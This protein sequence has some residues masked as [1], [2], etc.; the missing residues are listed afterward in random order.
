MTAPPDP[1]PENPFRINVSESQ[2]SQLQQ[3]LALTVLPSELDDAGW[4][5]GSPL[6]DIQRLVTRWKDGYSWKKYEAELN[7]ELPQFMRD[8]TVDGFGTLA[9]HYVHKRSQIPNAVPLLFVHGWPG[10]FIEVRKILPLL[11]ETSAEHPSFHV[12]ALSLPGF[13]F[14]DGPTKKGFNVARY[15]EVANKLMLSLGYQEYVTQGGDWGYYVTRAMAVEHG[16]KHLKAWHT[17]YPRSAS[18]IHPLRSP[19]KYLNHLVKPYTVSEQAALDRTAQFAKNGRGYIEIQCT[20]PQTLGFG[21]SDSPV[22]L[23]AWIYEKLQTWSDTNTYKWSDDEVL[24][25]VSIYWFSRAGPAA[26]L[27]IY[28]EATRSGDRD[29]TTATWEVKV[30]T[31]V[32]FFPK[33]FHLPPRRFL[34]FGN[35]VSVAEHTEEE[36]GGHFAAYEKPNLLVG[37]LRKMF[38]K[39]GGAFGAVTG[40]NGYN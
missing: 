13:G 17:N 19:L 15:A 27:R 10:S 2:I 23:L 36:G 18:A 24:T 25:W 5:Y 22:G 31:G 30:P 38:G 3:K 21:L 4:A 1:Y 26:S 9:I 6:P 20:Q 29:I 16:G 7:D 28:Y 34:A 32:S 37:D 8:I 33:E 11:I 35:L 14:S 12:V 40:K 39:T